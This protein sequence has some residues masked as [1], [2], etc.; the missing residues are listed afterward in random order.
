MAWKLIDDASPTV[1]NLIREAHRR[2][3]TWEIGF[4][5]GL[6][7]AQREP[8]V[9]TLLRGLH[10]TV[11]RRY[12]EI[13]SSDLFGEGETLRHALD[14]ARSNDPRRT[15]PSP[16]AVVR[17]AKCLARDEPLLLILDEFGKNL[18]AVGDSHDADPYLLQQ[19]A[20]AGQASGLPIFILT[21]QHLSFEDY[22]AHTD[23]PQRREWT[24]VQG[25]FDDIAYTESGSQARALIAPVFTVNDER[26]RGRVQTW[27]QSQAEAMRS[28][29]IAD[30]ASPPTVEACYPLHPLTA[31]VLPELC[32]RYGQQERTLFSFL[33]GSD[34]TSAAT[35]LKN[36]ELSEDLPLPSLGL[37][38]AYDYFVANGSTAGA[39]A[40]Q[41]SRWTEIATRLRD[42]Q[43]LSPSQARL[44]KAV[45]LLNLVSTTGPLR[46]SR[47]LLGA[48]SSDTDRNLSR[49]EAAGILTYRDFADEYR[50][51]QGS[52][53]DIPRLLAA[54][55]SQVQRRSLVEVLSEVDEPRPVVAARHSAR[56]D[57]LRVFSRRYVDGAG[58]V[59]PQDPFYPYDGE[60]LLVVESV[61][62]VPRL[63]DSSSGAKPV[64]AAMPNDI[65][66][67]DS[68][69]REIAAISTLL[70]DPV[71]SRDWVAR[72]EL[73]ERLAQARIQF[74]A[75][76]SS[77]FR[78]DT[79]RWILVDAVGGIELSADRGSSALSHAA[80]LAYPDTPVVGNEM[81]NRSNLTSQGAKARRLLIEAMIE[82]GWEQ[83]L[84]LSGFGPEMA[85][86]RAFLQDTGL[87]RATG[88]EGSWQF[89]EPAERRLQP[90]WAMIQRE[91]ERAKGRRINL[92]DIFA[93]LL[94]PPVGMKAG[95]VPILITAAL[96]AR[97]NEIA[98]YAHGTFQPLLTIELAE[99]MVRN[100]G[101]FE[102]KHF[103]NTVGAREEVVRALA[104]RLGVRSGLERY[105]VANVLSVVSHLVRRMNRLENYARKTR[106]ISHRAQRARSTLFKAV[107]PDELL[108]D[109][110]PEALGFARVPV[111]KVTYQSAQPY[112]NSLGEVVDELAG[113]FEEML[114]GLLAFLLRT[115]GERSRDPV[116]RQAAA[117]NHE[118]LNQEIRA[119]V[120]TLANDGVVDHR[121]WIKAIATVVSRKAPAEWT[122]EDLQ[123][124]RAELPH[125]LAAL[126]RLAALHAEP[127]H[128]GVGS[129]LRV[130][131]TGEDGREH[132]R[133]VDIE[134]QERAHAARVLDDAVQDLTATVGSPRRAQEALL[135]LL[136]ERLLPDN[137][138][139]E[140]PNALDSSG[141]RTHNG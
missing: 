67:L 41:S 35:F 29:G 98:I 51:W 9:R 26:L 104:A 131:I 33:A 13:P 12:E 69:A 127:D 27:A 115:A 3:R 78:A 134:E 101:L 89:C 43:G 44:A 85:M 76:S 121:D 132:I 79:C 21:L 118:A 109:T 56:H 99:R 40:S 71:V 110:L 34:P 64:V 18:E 73:S 123:L 103:A 135:A 25:R 49:L 117:L 77:T 31:M 22:L 23:G 30:L 62:S 7:T 96:L 124:F 122:D 70:N 54:A 37:D 17:I 94:S 95:P 86:Y 1:G 15:G 14:D 75:A 28:L 65:S 90:A 84:G 46:A 68:A 52:E 38:T 82:R 10:A 32:N 50:I 136:G 114:D 120:L 24:K 113:C 116:V 93:V 129:R 91:F 119:F 36:S 66:A 2:H 141:S 16:A 63:S 8:L 87:H 72:R 138:R 11:L 125:Q 4:H 48:L 60:V 20:E 106:E 83:G 128:K 61:G 19:L 139:P 55:R 74:E 100:P 130:A 39:A 47:H 111:K 58:S 81:L 88:T 80:D 45:A 102:V 137:G 108:F 59:K 42:A 97:Q 133:F 53:F 112:A 107:E 6:V 140:T 92:N 105:R 5:R 126:Q 57:V